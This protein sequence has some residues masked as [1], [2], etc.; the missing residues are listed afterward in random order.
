MYKP[1]VATDPLNL[2][3]IGRNAN[4]FFTELRTA[5][6][7]A[8]LIVFGDSLARQWFESLVCFLRAEWDGWQ[9]GLP[10]Q[11]IEELAKHIGDDLPDHNAL[12]VSA[13]EW[14]WSR[15]TVTDGNRTGVLEYFQTD[16]LE[17]R[18]ILHVIAFTAKTLAKRPVYVLD[19]GGC[20]HRV[21][22]IGRIMWSFADVCRALDIHCILR[23][24]H[25]THFN[26][27]TG[28]YLGRHLF[29]ATGYKSCKPHNAL[30]HCSM[31][32]KTEAIWANCGHLRI[33][34]LF[35]VSISRGEAHPCPSSKCRSVGVS[36]GHR[37]E[38]ETG[39]TNH[40]R[41]LGAPSSARPL[42]TASCRCPPPPIMRP[43]PRP[44][45]G[46]RRPP[47][48]AQPCRSA[49]GTTPSR[50]RDNKMISVSG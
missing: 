13:G 10:S 35:D 17:L 50:S 16:D 45:S 29:N 22:D 11:V 6:S 1:C 27:P 12:H 5:L 40:G 37:D 20:N 31:R 43:R 2:R 7:D 26:S 23:E 24:A 25:P 4:R 34:P 42:G 14:G 33:L 19:G 28:V 18:H 9:K 30:C 36:T 46:L 49:T 15:T 32:D 8:R 41:P 38:G 21:S 3:Y 39:Y 47:L 44:S 48:V